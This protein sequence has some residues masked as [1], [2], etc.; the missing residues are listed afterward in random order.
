MAE[1]NKSEF[2]H[3][4]K[5]GGNPFSYGSTV[6]LDG[7]NYEIWSRVF[8]MSVIGH[9]KEHVI[10]EKEPVEKS[11]KYV[12]WKGDNNIV[13]SW[14]MN[15]VQP[16]IASTIAYYTSAKQMWDFLKQTY[17]N[18]KNV[19]KILQVEEELL[20]LQQGDQSLA[21]YFASLKSISE[22]LKALRPPCPTCYK[23]HGEQSMVAKFLQGLS[24]EYA[25]AKAQ[26]LIGAEIPDLAEAYN[27]LSRLAVTLSSSSSDI[28]A[29]AL[30]ASGVR[31]RSLFRGRGMG[32]G[33][34]VGRGRFQ[35]TYC[36]KIGH[37]EDRCWD[38]HGRPTATPSLGRNVTSKPGKNSLQSSI[39][40]AQAAS[41]VVD[42][43]LSS[44]SQP[45]TVTVSINKSEYEDFLAHRSTQPSASTVMIDSAMSIDTISHDTGLRLVAAQMKMPKAAPSYE[46]LGVGR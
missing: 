4:V 3:E 15:S 5:S 10:E 24:S 7:S 20:N 30:A 13:M 22:R 45:E 44:S 25:V 43:S 8:M 36:G 26:M 2:S 9:Q 34:G 1:I 29:S 37:L 6:K 46:S 41:S 32:R 40:S 14:I 28:H 38:K 19:S 21:Q 18:D 39:G 16:Q 35:C 33:S 12:S 17:S 11:G 27:R 42:G 31:G 23:T